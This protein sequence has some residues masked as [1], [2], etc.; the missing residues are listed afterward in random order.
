MFS[1]YYN[2]KK[3]ITMNEDIKKYIKKNNFKIFNNHYLRNNKMKEIT[4]VGDENSN[5][6]DYFFYDFIENE[7]TDLK[8]CN[9]SKMLEEITKNNLNIEKYNNE[10]TNY[11]KKIVYVFT[12][13]SIVLLVTFFMSYKY[14][15]QLR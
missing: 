8:E 5:N 7:D 14:Y 10:I 15:L 1:F 12:S 6:N 11:K 2:K 13:S 9:Q 3:N 4:L